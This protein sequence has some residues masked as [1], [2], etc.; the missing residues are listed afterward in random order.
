[1]KRLYLTEKPSQI[2]ALKKVVR[3]NSTFEPLAGHLFSLL[4][5]EEYDTSLTDWYRAVINNKLPFTPKEF[6]KRIS[7]TVTYVTKE[8]KTGEQN[9]QKI[10]NSVKKAIANCDEIV[11]ASDPD[12]EGAS[13]AYE[14]IQ[15]CGAEKKVKGMM[16]MA[17][18]DP[19][20][21]SKSLK[22]FES[23]PNTIDYKNMALA[24][25]TRAVFDWSFGMNL[26]MG[27]TVAL[28]DGQ[29]LNMGGVKLPTI[30]MVVERDL[31]FENFEEIPF[32]KL[33]ATAKDPKTGKEFPIEIKYNGLDKIDDEKMANEAFENVAKEFTI[34][35]YS[36]TPKKAIPSKPFSLLDMAAE[37]SR[38]NGL[39]MVRSES[40]AQSLYDKGF[41]SYPR[42]EERFYSDG[43]H[44]QARQV[45]SGLETNGEFKG[46]KSLKTPYKKRFAFDDKKLV[47]KAHGAL[48]PTT[49]YCDISSLNNDEKIVYM[50]V[51]KRY[52]SQ[53]M[54][55]YEYSNNTIKASDGK[56]TITT[57]ENI[58]GEKGWKELYQNL[59]DTTT[60][61]LPVM[62][63]GDK[64]FILD[65]ELEK[66]FTKP[67]GRFNDISLAQ[68]MANIANHYDNEKIVEYLSESGIGTSATRKQ[69]IQELKEDKR[70]RK[71]IEP[72]FIFQNGK[73]VS[74]PKSRDLI[75]LLPNNVTSP[76]LR[77]ELGALTKDVEFGK[78]TIDQA[79]VEI[80]D[81]IKN[82]YD[83]IID[84]GKEKGIRLFNIL[85]DDDRSTKKQVDFV[86]K[87]AKHNGIDV[88]D[89]VL[90]DKEKISEWIDKN[91]ASLRYPLSNKQRKI[92]SETKDPKVIKLLKQ[93]D[94]S[95]NDMFKINKA[96]K[97]QLKEN[98]KDWRYTLSPKQRA[99]LEKPE[100]ELTIDVEEL[101]KKEE[102][103][104]PEFNK[105]N[106]AIK[107]I[108]AK[109]REYDNSNRFN[110]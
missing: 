97:F 102:F 79:K 41:Q 50:A 51:A 57:S 12:N 48:S 14:V 89:G 65:V 28:G 15:A 76:V 73:I 106:K 22:E 56:Y 40:A 24:S 101:L 30:R 66:G 87:M 19:S 104:K 25:D 105:L 54:D 60:K 49:K 11:I 8:G 96:I 35:N 86:T 94:F 47:G 91:K 21:L 7:N 52:Y 42:T 99:V 78:K 75:E 5:P 107:E 53:F 29:V 6:K 45:I 33:K 10:F 59:L 98:A 31:A 34:S 36:E 1:L 80:K 43:E 82:M 46:L 67:K 103:T 69:I 77:A 62:E 72:Y 88:A 100:N 70:G 83:S 16:N 93:D 68:A 26:S 95:K 4:K 81:Q 18:I 38:T 92:L 58:Q 17:F 74:T 108:F 71:T 55:D 23:N 9:Y 110:R 3:D 85:G 63:K 20:S 90:D 64:L 13:L 109:P 44:D 32:W 27:A 61:S 37:V 39:S 84:V 2:V